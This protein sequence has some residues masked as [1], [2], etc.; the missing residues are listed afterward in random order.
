MN[1][2]KVFLRSKVARRIFFLF[3]T[4]A[5]IPI[6][7][8]AI[9]SFTQVTKQLHNQSQGR[10]R[11]TVKDTE[12]SIRERLFL[13]GDEMR[14]IASNLMAASRDFS[15]EKPME[16]SASQKEHFK[17]IG[18]INKPGKYMSLFDCSQDI[19]EITPAEREH[20]LSGKFLISTEYKPNNSSSILK[21]SSI[22]MSMALD[23]ANQ[24]QEILLA[25]INPTYLWYA[26]NKESLPPMT[27][28]CVLDESNNL[29]ESSIINLASFPEQDAV[30]LRAEHSGSL[31]WRH[32]EEGY[33][34]SYR[35]LALEDEYL[36]PSLTLVMSISK[37]Y[38]LQPIAL[39]KRV[40]P[41]IILM[42]L[43]VV[44]LLSF[45]Q[46]RR[47]LIPLER[48][49]VGTQRIA[50]REFDSR[51]TV[52][53]NDE[54]EDLAESFNT[55]ADQLGRQF[56]ALV[57]M[58]ELDRAIL[59]ALDTKRIADTAITRMNDVV[60]CD[61][62]SAT[63]LDSKD[64]YKAE[65]Y[66]WVEKPHK[67]RY[68]ETV[69]FKPE[70][71]QTL[72]DNEESL[73]IEPNRNSLYYLE[74]MARRGFKSFLVLPI[75]LKKKL[76]GTITLGYLKPPI[77]SQEDVDQ[78]RRLVNQVAVAISNARLIEELHDLNWGALTALARAID[79]KSPW[80]AGH[81]ERVTKLALKIGRVMRLSKK[82]LDN[83]N[84][85]GLM[86]DLGKIGIPP[87]I[88]DKP[89][90]LTAEE[91]QLMH[92]HVQFGVRILKPIAAY[93]EVIPIVMHHHERLDGSG[94]PDGLA[95]EDI[96]LGGYIYSVADDFD[97]LSTDRPYRKALPRKRIINLIKDRSGSKYHPKVVE[98]FLEVIDQEEREEKQK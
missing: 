11:K 64:S 43:W 28:L 89:G 48:L 38:V 53:S 70:D 60:P 42:S 6:I 20:L 75:F 16:F 39:F 98:A 74:P 90:K 29:L 71:I 55:M 96:S 44:I 34:A 35:S 97:A 25:E 62:V 32:D 13:I 69:E 10:L 66:I 33:M 72:H 7:A 59:S 12:M 94:Y 30:K 21:L 81:S 76:A 14:I 82:E 65:T 67:K 92:K 9:I 4:C 18:I 51:V 85:G 58:G 77:I 49:K 52:T 5:L 61:A 83:L 47:N 31:E 3:I 73:F 8:L 95:G 84:R 78:V 26:G 45:S 27:H 56:K 23:S 40:F 24:R 50:K 54:F 88:L 22:H 15:P 41:F 19:P 1:L 79:A 37:S 46:I 17:C 87:E 91:T 57:T 86:H 63:L 2:E 80:T 36:A 68:V 93:A